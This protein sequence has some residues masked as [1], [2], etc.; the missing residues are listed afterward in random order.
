MPFCEPARERKPNRPAAHCG[1]VERAGTSPEDHRLSQCTWYNLIEG[2]L[3]EGR[4]WVKRFPH[5]LAVIGRISLS[6]AAPF[7]NHRRPDIPI[8][9]L[10]YSKQ[11][12]PKPATQA[13][14]NSAHRPKAQVQSV[15]SRQHRHS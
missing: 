6:A 8:S 14:A 10:S 4:R 9:H 15:H 1:L 3:L 7:S 11:N 12:E 2:G 5:N 13:G